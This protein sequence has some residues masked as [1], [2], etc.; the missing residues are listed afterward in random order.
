MASPDSSRHYDVIVIG[1]GSMGSAACWHLARRGQ[2]VLGLEQFDIPHQHGSHA[3]QSR[4][5]R[6]AYFEHPDYVPLLLRAY[7]N[8]RSFEK[9]TG[10]QL[11]YRTGIAYFGR[12]DN[13]NIAGVRN[14]ARLHNI[15][16]A[17]WSAAEAREQYP[18][19]RVPADFDVI[20]EP[21]A[22]FITPER[23]VASF[24]REA[25]KNGAVIKSKTPVLEWRRE[26]GRVVVVTPGDEYTS[27]KLVITAGAWS[28]RVIPQLKITLRITRQ[29]LAWVSPPRP[30]EFSLNSFP[31]WF[32][33]DPRV[34]TFYGFPLLRDGRFD[35]P[36]GL[37]LAH[38]YPGVPCGADEVDGDIPPS[39]EEKLKRFLKTYVPSAGDHI[40]EIRKCLY[41]SSDDGHFVID[42]LPGAD[43]R[44]VLACG[45][46]GHGFK[47][48]PAI[49]EILADLAVDG[50]TKLPIDFLRLARFR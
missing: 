21:D 30:E 4:I 34:G 17:S 6:K 47:F 33:E 3:G 8:W 45:F 16:I 41:T 12:K 5:I 26:G 42:H 1:V 35:G 15:R 20:F 48:V 46:S 37:K 29:L 10:S 43:R 11:Y 13:E 7:E 24:A 39:E 50:A 25:S 49:G 31:C 28:S 32:V 22:G 40:V 23:A 44:V 2:K 19:F 14:S 18:S 27:D 36:I 9:E 38:H